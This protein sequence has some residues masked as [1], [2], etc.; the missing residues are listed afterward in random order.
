MKVGTI[1]F[2]WAV[3]YGAVLQS[4]ALQKYIMGVGIKTEIIDYRP[5][6]VGLIQSAVAFLKGN[7]EYYKKKKKI[8][9]FVKEE[10]IISSKIYR[11]NR[12]LHQITDEY[13][14]VFVGSDQI[15]NTSFLLNAEG[16]T[17]LSYYL[18][19]L[20]PDIRRVS[21]AASFGTDK[22]SDMEM[23][24]VKPWLEIFYLIS[25]REKSGID[26]MKGMGLKSELVLDPVFLLEAR[27]YLKLIKSVNQ[28]CANNMFS[29]IL[30]SGQTFSEKIVSFF[31]ELYGE[32]APNETLTVYEWLRQ[33]KD[34]KLVVTNSFHCV[35]FSIIFHT[36]FIVTLVEGS[37]MNGR[38]ETLLMH[39]GLHGRVVNRYDEKHLEYLA[40]EEIDWEQIESKLLSLK[41]SSKD[42]IGRAL[43]E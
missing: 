9:R 23:E 12:M 24:L 15:W 4:Y 1:T 19:F 28:S 27:D 26:I 38:I 11:N 14:C 5:L 13:D 18:D 3:N 41:K 17:T 29:Y 39:V 10:L 2:H 36:P 22:L 31:R 33:I 20:R 32:C 6:R 37:Q 16:K 43:R 25:V 35:A 21:Y 42:F 40:K 30:H 8:R 7:R 34:A